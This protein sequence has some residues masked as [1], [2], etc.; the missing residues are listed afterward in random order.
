[1]D[2]RSPICHHVEHALSEMLEEEKVNLDEGLRLHLDKCQNCWSK[3]VETRWALSRDTKP[4]QELREFLG[5]DFIDGVDASWKLVDDWHSQSRVSVEDVEE[6]YRSTSWYVYSLVLWEASGQ[7]PDYADKM[8][9]FLKRKNI[10]HILDF[11]AGVG[12]DTLKLARLVERVE[13]IEIN[14]KCRDFLIHRTREMPEVVVL[15]GSDAVRKG[16]LL[17]AMDVVEH[18]PTPIETLS[19]LLESFDYFVFDCEQDQPSSGRHPFHFQ[20]D[21]GKIDEDLNRI[22]FKRQ[23]NVGEINIYRKVGG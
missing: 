13:A 19:G 12:N 11:G 9:D 20:H 6:F 4:M 8:S 14:E 5:D 23:T 17:W 18:L 10:R 22:G 2:F 7:R 1:M 16:E 3:L 15:E 21:Q